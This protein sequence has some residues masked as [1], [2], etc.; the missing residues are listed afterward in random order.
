MV[1]FFG[2]STLQGSGKEVSFN[3]PTCGPVQG[4]YHKPWM[5]ATFFFVPV[6]PLGPVE[7]GF[8]NCQNCSGSWRDIVLDPSRL[9]TYLKDVE[10][11]C[12]HH[13]PG[14]FC[15]GCGRIW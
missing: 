8:V 15:H 13:R 7:E 2:Y 12:K 14:E 6:I 5:W 3:C 9:A 1:V 4:V 11:A 10:E